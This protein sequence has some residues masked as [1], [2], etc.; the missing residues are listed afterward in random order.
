M[1]LLC[2]Q[3]ARQIRIAIHILSISLIIT[4]LYNSNSNI[5]HYYPPLHFS[6]LCNN[7]F[8]I[9]FRYISSRKSFYTDAL[10][11]SLTK[12]TQILVV[13]YFH[14][15]SFFS[16]VEKN[17]RQFHFCKEIASKGGEEVLIHD[18]DAALAI[19]PATWLTS[20]RSSS[21][22]QFIIASASQPQS[23]TI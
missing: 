3:C 13:V 16:C 8:I 5:S 20:Y 14:S 23:M 18:A 21:S 10:L 7:I 19:C 2:S 22:R 4:Y 9:I 6:E 11:F 17:F 15:L 1:C 12:S